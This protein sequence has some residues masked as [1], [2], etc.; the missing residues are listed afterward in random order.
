M[1]YKCLEAVA[2]GVAVFMGTCGTWQVV[3]GVEAEAQE[4]MVPPADEE[5]EFVKVEHM[6]PLADEVSGSA[7]EKMRD[8]YL[9]RKERGWELGFSVKN[10][11]GAYIGWGQAD[12]NVEA[13]DV[14]AGQ[15]R[16]LAFEKA[17]ADAKGEFVRAKMR[18]TTT[19]TLREL[20]HDGREPSPD[21]V[22]DR[23]SRAKVIA[24]KVMA[25]K[26]A[27]LDE[28]LT[29]LGV[30]P[31]SFGDALPKKKRILLRDAISRRICVR[32]VQSV[33]GMRVLTTF[34]DQ[35]GV[36]VLVVWSDNMR[37]IA[38]AIASGRTVGRPAR[39]DPKESIMEQIRN[40]CED[41]PAELAFTH[42]VRVMTDDNGDRAL[43]AFGQWSPAVTRQDSK[44]KQ[45]MAIRAARA[46]AQDLADG[47][48]T[49]FVNNSVVLESETAIEGDDQIYR[50]L[51][52]DSEEEVE[53]SLIGDYLRRMVKQHGR[54]TVKGVVTTAQWKANHPETGHLLVGH[55]L[56]WSPATRDAVEGKPRRVPK[57]PVGMVDLEN[58]QHEGLDIG[59]EDF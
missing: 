52:P 9:S 7:L 20:F 22:K 40:A 11:S 57:K 19:T 29:E 49:D 34:E 46:Q 42:G 39:R 13:N 12:I 6:F 18:T 16:V 54:A 30:D 24:D 23:W 36:G 33:A 32:A 5:K 2:M 53:A 58:R 35:N 25:L 59:N 3:C 43:V 15:A 4:A 44:M 48:L 41:Y 21:Q 26:D 37:R 47:A 38:K 8:A 31:T 14:K 56:M 17:L 51:S 45:N 55:V 1:K 10:P 28:K 50:L 27:R